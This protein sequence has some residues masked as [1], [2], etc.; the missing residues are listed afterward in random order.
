M[1]LPIALELGKLMFGVSANIQLFLAGAI[2]LNFLLVK[3]YLTTGIIISYILL[4]ILLLL[5]KFWMLPI[6]DARA[7]ML[8]SGKPVQ[9]TSLHDYFIYAEVGKLILTVG[10]ILLQL[11]K[12]K[13]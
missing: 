9:P 4:V 12:I 7:D 10:G 13:K 1:T 11:K 5:E 6:L 3:K 8:A 2:A